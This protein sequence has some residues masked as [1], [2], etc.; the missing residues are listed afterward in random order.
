MIYLK[1]LLGLPFF[2]GI[3]AISLIWNLIVISYLFMKHG[4]EAITYRNKCEKK[5]IADIYEELVK[6]R[7]PIG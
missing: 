2:I 6:Q 7:N 4:G 1:R 3:N 5:M